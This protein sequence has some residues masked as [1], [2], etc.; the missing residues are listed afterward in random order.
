MA[1][2]LDMSSAY[3]WVVEWVFIAAVMEKMGFT[4]A[5][6]ALIRQCI[7]SVSYSISLAGSKYE[8]FTPEHGLRQ[9]DPLSPFLFL[10]CMDGFM[11]LLHKLFNEKGCRGIALGRHCP[12]VSS[13]FFVDDV[14]ILCRADSK[15]ADCIK[16]VL[17]TFEKNSGQHASAQ[18]STILFSK[19]PSPNLRNMIS[20]A[21][22]IPHENMQEK[23]LGLP[24]MIN[25]SK[26]ATFKY[27]V[28][29]MLEKIESWSARFLSRA[30]KTVLIKSVMSSIPVFTMSC[31][32]ISDSIALSK[33]KQSLQSV[34]VVF[35][36]GQAMFTLG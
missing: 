15:H 27:I 33:N 17:E 28:A 12:E 3:D 22:N 32:Y 16:E 25:K 7:A 21:M 24:F 14:L 1:L 19:N 20:S 35:S 4:I 8:Y 31:F 2:K 10:L 5:F 23:H 6:I 9:G 34:F 18:K 11:H 29:R 30:G 36:A 26:K 13:L